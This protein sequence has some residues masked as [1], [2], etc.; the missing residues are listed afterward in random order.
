MIS[1]KAESGKDTVANHIYNILS[2][3]G[4]SVFIIHF[5]DYLK[6][7]CSTYL[8]WDGKK[9]E[10]G[11]SM[12]QNIANE[13]FR[14]FNQDYFAE[15]TVET[16]KILATNYDYVLIPDLRYTNE[17]ELVKNNFD[18]VAI[19]V[20]RKNHISTL[21][22]NQLENISETNLDNYD[23]PYIITE[24]EISKKLEKTNQILEEILNGV[25]SEK[26]TAQSG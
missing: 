10:Y 20:E 22:K 16:I 26:D 9:D 18:S 3:A 6:F 11:R 25:F 12:L 5:A 21:T 17:L 23:F 1:G 24:E 14:K 8:G 13:H 19:R 15:R 4:K 7:A 2:S